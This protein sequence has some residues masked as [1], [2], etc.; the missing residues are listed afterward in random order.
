MSTYGCAPGLRYRN[1]LHAMRAALELE[2]AVG[3]LAGNLEDDF[4][5]AA[6]IALARVH[7]LDAPALGFRE[8]GVHAVQIRRE[9]RRLV[10][11]G[12]AA[13]L[14]DDVFVV[15]GIL[16]QQ[17]DAHFLGKLLEARAELLELHLDHLA[18]LVVELLRLH[19]LGVLV[20]GMHLLVFRIGVVCALQI[21][22]LLGKIAQPLRIAGYIRIAQQLAQLVVSVGQRL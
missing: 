14:D 20:L 1:A 4:L 13:D 6:E 9:Q 3:A 21:R 8:A 7:Q 2:L 11:A 19:R 12:R 16:G 18:H 10:A 17:Q 22:L 15:V 5:E